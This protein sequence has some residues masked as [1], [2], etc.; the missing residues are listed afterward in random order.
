MMTPITWQSFSTKLF[1]LDIAPNW[2][3]EDARK[4]RV[5]SVQLYATN[6]ESVKAFTDSQ[7]NYSYENGMLTVA[8]KMTSSELEILNKIFPNNFSAL[9]E[10][11]Q[12]ANNPPLTN[13]STIEPFSKIDAEK[14]DV[15]VKYM[16]DGEFVN[17]KIDFSTAFQEKKEELSPQEF[18]QFIMKRLGI[19]NLNQIKSVKMEPAKDA[20][21][22]I[23][24]CPGYGVTEDGHLTHSTEKEIQTMYNMS[25]CVPPITPQEF[26]IM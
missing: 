18:D 16:K 23:L 21:G 9:T 25:I 5:S 17:T 20:N 1:S 19:S 24:P 12:K 2:Q 22:E 15:Y 8:G 10:L 14:A 26:E 6:L 3:V 13:K 4:N 7:F 11:M